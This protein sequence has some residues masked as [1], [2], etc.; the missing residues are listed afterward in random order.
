MIDTLGTAEGGAWSGGVVKAVDAVY[1]PPNASPRGLNTALALARTGTPYMQKRKGVTC[2]TTEP[3]TGSPAIIG[4]HDYYEVS[5]STRR[6]LC[7]SSTQIA[8]KGL[9]GTYTVLS[10]DLT[11]STP[12]SM[13]TANNMAFLVNGTDAKKVRGTTVE[14]IGI[15][16][17]TVGTMSG[18]VGIAGLHDGTYELRVAYKNSATGHLSSAS[19]TASATVTCTNDKIDWANIPVSADP[20][21]DQKVL[22]VRNVATQAYFF[23]ADTIANAAT[24]ATTSVADEN[25]TTLAPTRTNRAP[26]PSGAKYLAVFKGRL[27]AASAA[28]LFWTPIDEP[29]AFDLS[30]RYDLVDTSGDP[31]TGLWVEQDELIVLKDDRTFVIEGDLGGNYAI[32]QVDANIGCLA[33]RTVVSAGGSTYWWSRQGIVRYNGQTVERIGMLTYG[34]P[35]E[36]V[37]QDSISA[38][39]GVTHDERGTIYFALPEIGQDRATFMLP[40]NYVL[41]VC[42]SE[43]WDPMDIASL[44]KCVDGSGVLQPSLGGYAGQV[45]QLWSGHNDGVRS[46][47]LNTGTFVASSD[48][49]A[50]LAI[51]GSHDVTTDTTGGGNIERKITILDST[52]TIVTTGY[53]PHITTIPAVE[54]F[55]EFTP[56]VAVTNGA[57]YTVIIG[58]PNFEFDTPWRNY[59][60]EWTKKRFEFLFVLTKGEGYGSSSDVTMSFDYDDLNLNGKDRTFTIAQEGAVWDDAVWDTDVF[61]TALNTFKRLRAARTGRAWRTRFT[62]PYADQPFAVLEIAAQAERQTTKR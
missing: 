1:L 6:H 46:S 57:T 52:G 19:D 26:I 32:R 16:R 35:A 47:T 9:D 20:Q 27:V 56:S 23:I 43:Y 3:L 39:S 42:E 54:N 36:R 40:F 2:L 15:T 5:T 18:A 31:I 61:D 10:S 30:A 45:F 58:G 62:N 4:Q 33:H 48:N 28:S 53:R 60:D 49:I 55:I 37:N 12:P 50:S 51:L 22:L 7:T 59:G 34:D 24:T 44:G 21:V 14:G 41:G 11:S 17:P 13:V 29:E 38:A 25:L 8:V